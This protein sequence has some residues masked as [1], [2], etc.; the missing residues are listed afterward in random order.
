MA[1]KQRGRQSAASASVVPLG[2]ALKYPKAPNR[3]NADGK[4]LWERIVRSR[5]QNFFGP[6]D[7]PML[8][9]YCWNATV[10]IPKLRK[11]L[12]SDDDTSRKAFDLYDR[13]V[14]TNATLS[15]K[16]RLCPSSRTRP[17]SSE[18][19]RGNLSNAPPWGD[20]S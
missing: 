6:G 16:L 1:G 10:L 17:D 11:Q 14:R 8:E 5:A 19:K 13:T 18:A 20:A 7:L 4:K 9:H 3:L 12:E 15:G 2:D